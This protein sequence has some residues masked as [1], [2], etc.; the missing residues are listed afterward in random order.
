ME[1]L[2]PK[3][4]WLRVQCLNRSANSPPF[5][6][7]EHIEWTIT[8]IGHLGRVVEGT[9]FST[10]QGQLM[11]YLVLRLLVPC[12]VVDVSSGYVGSHGNAFIYQLSYRKLLIHLKVTKKNHGQEITGCPNT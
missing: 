9:G 10:C 7:L 2:E 5:N 4:S 12:E 8:Q 3:I 6:V 1:G 11:I